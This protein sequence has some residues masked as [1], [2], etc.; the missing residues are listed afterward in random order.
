[1]ENTTQNHKFVAPPRDPTFGRPG[2]KEQ[3]RVLRTTYTNDRNE[4]PGGVP[5]RQVGAP[6]AGRTKFTKTALN[7]NVRSI[8]AFFA[9][10]PR[11]PF[12]RLKNLNFQVI[13]PK[14]KEIKS[15]HQFHKFLNFCKFSK[16]CTNILTSS[17]IF[18]YQ[19]FEK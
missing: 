6:P 8:F 10:W 7:A 2:T 1:L 13:E 3:N 19:P 18:R 9:R 16:N 12:F 15:V 5:D 11:G 4:A 17:Q 14:S